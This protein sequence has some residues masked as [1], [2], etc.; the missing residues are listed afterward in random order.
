MKTTPASLKCGFAWP[1]TYG[2]ECGAD[3]TQIA[4]STSNL[5]HS[6]L[7]YSGR[8][9]VHAKAK[10]PDNSKVIRLE[11]IG[12]TEQTNDWNGRYC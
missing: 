8:C 11:P 5:T 3:A 12:A 10:G 1:G 9:D 6:G 2:H 4:V 7:F